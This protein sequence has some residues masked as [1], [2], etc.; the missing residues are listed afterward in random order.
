[1]TIP[2]E[3]HRRPAPELKDGLPVAPV[4]AMNV[5]LARV[6]KTRLVSLEYKGNGEVEAV[7]VG[8]GATF[9]TASENEIAKGNGTRQPVDGVIARF[10]V[11][12]CIELEQM[13]RGKMAG[14]LDAVAA[15]PAEGAPMAYVGQLAAYESYTQPDNAVWIYMRSWEAEQFAVFFDFSADAVDTFVAHIQKLVG[16]L[17]REERRAGR[18]LAPAGLF[19]A[20]P[21]PDDRVATAK[22]RAG[23]VKSV[24]L[25]FRQSLT[26]P[27]KTPRKEISFW[28]AVQ[29][30]VNQ[31]GALRRVMVLLLLAAMG[32]AQEVGSHGGGAG[33]TM[34]VSIAAIVLSVMT[35]LGGLVWRE[36]LG[37][38]KRRVTEVEHRQQ[39][40][41]TD[42]AGLNERSRTMSLSID[43]MSVSIDKLTSEMVKREEWDRRHKT[44]DDTLAE[45]KGMVSSLRDK[46]EEERHAARPSYPELE[47]P[48]RRP[49]IP[50]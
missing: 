31:V 10:M 15:P 28:E 23:E 25:P 13:L 39:T 44:T 19:R 3:Y 48:P 12:T 20:G 35:G 40:Q 30:K 46:V 16:G 2:R 36:T 1:M 41:M 47:P 38:L 50:R 45:I 32:M 8:E 37:E 9:G 34:V 43:R 29:Q 14:D 17:S 11:G 5:P 21:M 49:I 27:T 33:P 4:W 24:A 42:L 6:P 22:E 26:A 7:F 18:Q